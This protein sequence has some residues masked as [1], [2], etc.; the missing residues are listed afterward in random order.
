MRKGIVVEFWTFTWFGVLPVRISNALIIYTHAGYIRWRQHVSFRFEIIF[1]SNQTICKIHLIFVWQSLKTFLSRE[2][3]K[4]W[5]LS[6]I[7][8]HVSC[9]K[10]LHGRQPIYHISLYTYAGSQDC[11]TA[12]QYNCMRWW[13]VCP[14]SKVH[15][16]NMGHWALL[17]T[18]WCHF[19]GIWHN[20]FN[21]PL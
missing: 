4:S 18:L 3:W 6:W 9:Q 1:L 16:A 14:D 13:H 8:P 17:F 11:H 5:S 21:F 12:C 15:V 20:V 10:L 2:I 7:L 19:T